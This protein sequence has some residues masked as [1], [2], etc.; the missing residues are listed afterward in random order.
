MSSSYGVPEL[1]EAELVEAARRGDLDSFGVLYQRHYAAMVGVAYCV[2][3][4]RH[5][6][7]DAAQA[8]AMMDK[9]RG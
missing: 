3:R 4:D 2:L 7:E 6:A 1:T 5:L 9:R 8:P